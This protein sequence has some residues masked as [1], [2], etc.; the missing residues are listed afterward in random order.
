MVSY[1]VATQWTQI[2]G[3]ILK[4]EEKKK[5]DSGAKLIS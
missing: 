4:G 2:N 5:G 1:H 3:P